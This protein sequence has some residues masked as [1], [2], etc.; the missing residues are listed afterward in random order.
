MAVV[1]L[2]SLADTRRL[3]RLLAAGLRELGPVALLLRGPLGSGKTTLTAALTAALPGGDL[4]E[5]GSPSFTICNYYPTTPPVLHADLYRSPG[6]PPEELE[7][8][9]DDG[10][11]NRYVQIFFR[12]FWNGQNTCRRSFYLKN[13][14]TY[15]L[16]RA[17]KGVC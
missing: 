1:T 9:L 2:H 11:I 12:S 3:G 15:R 13:I 10:R 7:E 6:S 17:R 5:V 4:A 8:A 16:M 14:W